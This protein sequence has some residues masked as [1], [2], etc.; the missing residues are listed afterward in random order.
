MNGSFAATAAD[1]GKF[2]ALVVWDGNTSADNGKWGVSNAAE[3]TGVADDPRMD[4]TIVLFN[5]VNE[6]DMS[7]T[8]AN[9]SVQGVPEPTSGLLLLLGVAGLALRRRRA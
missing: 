9:Q 2:Y 6:Y 5:A 4:G 3:L 1:N 7:V 8:Y